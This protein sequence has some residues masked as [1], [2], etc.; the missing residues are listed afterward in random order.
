MRERERE[1][2]L[3]PMLSKRFSLLVYDSFI[4]SMRDLKLTFLLELNIF[5]YTYQSMKH[6]YFLVFMSLVGL[7]FA[8]L[9]VYEIH[10]PFPQMKTTIKRYC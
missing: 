3:T 10:S 4:V 2:W 8:Y 6:V 7:T 5:V 9:D 1:R